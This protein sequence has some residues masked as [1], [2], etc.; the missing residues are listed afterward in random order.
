MGADEH[1]VVDSELRVH[2]IDGLR[3]V[4][5]SVMPDIVSGNLNAPTQMIAERAADFILGKEPLAPEY[6]RYH[7]Q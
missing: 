4:D 6:P 3:V 1:S 5:A 7:F 2:G